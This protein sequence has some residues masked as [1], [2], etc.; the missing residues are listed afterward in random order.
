LQMCRT[1]MKIAGQRPEVI[2]TTDMLQ[3]TDGTG[4]KMSKSLGN[5][6]ALGD[7]PDEVFGKVMSIP[8]TLLREYFQ[9]LTE[10]Q[11]GE[12]E[13]LQLRMQNGDINPM[14]VKLLLASD[15]VAAVHGTEGAQRAKANFVNK[16][17]KRNYDD[18]STDTPT[19]N[20]QGDVMAQLRE[21]RG[22]ISGKEVRRLLAAGALRH[23]SPSGTERKLEDIDEIGNLG[24]GHLRVGKTVIKLITE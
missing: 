20:P 4:V 1:V 6:V 8:D 13:Q 14:T 7:A 22:G 19:L 23:V 5:Y 2:I 16:F 18:L 11:P 21:A 10:L 12:W 3:G 17:S 9:M 24:P 15:I